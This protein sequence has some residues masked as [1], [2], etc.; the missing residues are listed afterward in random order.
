MN[1]IFVLSLAGIF[2]P[3]F[4]WAFT[5]LPQERWQVLASIPIRKNEKG[6]WHGVNITYYGFFSATAYLF[7]VTVFFLLAASVG[8]Q[9]AQIFVIGAIVIGLCVPAASLI[10]RLVE[11]KKFTFTVGG[12]SFVGIVTAPVIIWLVNLV[13]M[14]YKFPEI[15][16]F[17]TLAALS[18]AYI[19]GEGIGRLACISFGCCYGKPVSQVSEH[20]RG[21]FDKYHFTFYGPTKKV[22]YAG[23]L[24]GVQLVP[25]QGMTVVVYFMGGLAGMYLFL[26]GFFETALVVTLILSQ[27]WRVYSE[28]LRADYRG[29]KAISP[30]QVLAAVGVIYPLLLLAIFPL[31]V[32][33]EANLTR[34]LVTLWHPVVIVFLQL[35]WL[36]LFIHTG[37]SMVTGSNLSFHVH[38]DRI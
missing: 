37:W 26:Q 23:H 35:I 15:L 25:I 22:V 1:E 14:P 30:Y 29:G 9:L 32:P 7:A 11:G 20:L 17:P 36:G 2:L 5:T 28:T 19:F 4:Y 27:I 38:Q 24:E 10:A 21:F 16:L 12:A 18:I 3:V 31:D 6:G 33:I 34:G 8:L 13:F